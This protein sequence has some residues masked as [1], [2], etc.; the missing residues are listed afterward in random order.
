[1]SESTVLIGDLVRLHHE[2]YREDI[3]F[4]IAKTKEYNFV[5]ELGCGYGRVSLPLLEAGR[6]VVGLD[7][8]WHALRYLKSKI[9]LYDLDLQQRIHL[10]QADM[11]NFFMGEKFDSIIFPCNTYSSISSEGRRQL[12]E[13]L[14]GMLNSGGLFIVSMPNPEQMNV[15]RK[16]LIESDQNSEPEIETTFTHPEIK[17]PVQVSSLVS[18]SDAGIHWEWIYD[19]LKHDGNVERHRRTHPYFMSSLTTYTQELQDAGFNIGA[20]LGDFDESEFNQDS[21]HLILVARYI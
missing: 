18:L 2:D 8:D 10:V 14:A 6:K 1:M 3:P 15:L 20:C 16:S 19:L 5:L 13:N 11:H 7:Y 9:R 17:Y 12:L 21:P 4:W